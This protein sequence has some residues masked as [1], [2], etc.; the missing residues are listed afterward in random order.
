MEFDELSKR[1]ERTTREIALAEK[2]GNQQAVDRLLKN[3]LELNRLMRNHVII[4]RSNTP[5]AA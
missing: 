5:T 1:M 4:Y 3:K 2:E